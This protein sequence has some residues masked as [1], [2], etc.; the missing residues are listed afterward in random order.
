MNRMKVWIVG[1][2]IPSPQNKM[3]GSFELEQA[4]ALANAGVDV[5]YLALSVRSAKNTRHIGFHVYRNLSIPVYSF[6][7][8]MGRVLPQKIKDRVFNF[9]F[10]ALSKKIVNECGLPDVIHIHYPAQRPYSAIQKL[11]RQGVKIIA[12]EHWTKVLDKT[13]GKVFLNNLRDYVQEC[14]AFICVSS[15]LRQS[16]EELTG[17]ARQIHVVPNLVN[18]NFRGVSTVK[19]GFRFVVSGRLVELKQADKVVK[20]FINVFDKT[21]DVYLTVV[22]GGEQYNLLKRYVADAGWESQISLPGSVAREKMAEIMASSDV[23]VSYSR[24]ETFCVPVIEAWMCGKPVIASKTIPV[25]IDYHDDRLGITVDEHKI[26]TLE[27]ALLTMYKRYNGYNPKW[28]EQYAR[29]NFSEAAV[30]EKL[31]DIYRTIEA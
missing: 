3:L 19:D 7:F 22:G 5:K 12:T 1:R 2:G 10:S 18:A 28:I 20:A 26:E 16:V 27:M 9:A 6:N 8:P 25:M 31:K 21:E 15:T 4:Q 29:E 30:A 24:L 23:L 17:L 14:D 11:Q 13:I